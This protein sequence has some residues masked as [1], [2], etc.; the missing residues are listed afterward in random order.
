MAS[1]WKKPKYAMENYYFQE[2]WRPCWVELLKYLVSET[3]GIYR[4]HFL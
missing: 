4:H 3:Q 1:I 2:S